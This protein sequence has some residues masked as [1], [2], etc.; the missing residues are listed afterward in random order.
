M[1]CPHYFR[2]N[3]N[4]CSPPPPSLVRQTLLVQGLFITKASQSHSVQHTTCGRT[5]LDGRSAQHRD[6]Y[7][8]THNPHKRQKSITS[9]KFAPTNPANG[10]MQTHALDHTAT[11]IGNS[12]QFEK[13]APYIYI[14][15][16]KQNKKK[17]TFLWALNVLEVSRNVQYLAYTVQMLYWNTLAP[18][19]L[20]MINNH[21]NCHYIFISKIFLIKIWARVCWFVLCITGSMKK[22]KLA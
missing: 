3:S 5:P 16:Q 15:K 8:T 12:M 22:C 20:K 18:Y 10:Q 1:L 6:L 14:Y 4:H 9:A 13:L 2:S 7:L 11:G 21:F 19:N 17:L